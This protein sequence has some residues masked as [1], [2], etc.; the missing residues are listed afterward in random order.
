[1]SAL[2]LMYSLYADTNPVR[3]DTSG[4]PVN[5]LEPRDLVSVLRVVEY[6]IFRFMIISV[7]VVSDKHVPC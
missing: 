6:T 1:M 5:R 3:V 4:E 2:I 7:N